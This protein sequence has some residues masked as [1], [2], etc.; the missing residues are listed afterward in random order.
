MYYP[1]YPPP[2]IEQVFPAM[3]PGDISTHVY[4]G[5]HGGRLMDWDTKVRPRAPLGVA[6]YWQN[7][8]VPCQHASTALWYVVARGGGAS[9]RRGS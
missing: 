5:Y 1:Y 8:P 6:T 4:K 7:V 3:R 2:S 9:R